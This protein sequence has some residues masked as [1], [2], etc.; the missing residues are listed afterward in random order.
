MMDPS[1]VV[2]DRQTLTFSPSYCAVVLKVSKLG[3][4]QQDTCAAEE[5]SPVLVNIG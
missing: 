5:K 2:S 4:S 3:G 1:F